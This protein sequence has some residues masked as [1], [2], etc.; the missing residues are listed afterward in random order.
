MSGPGWWH[1]I[2]EI[3]EVKKKEEEALMLLN[4]ACQLSKQ[5][6]LFLFLGSSRIRENTPARGPEAAP[7]EL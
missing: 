5:L 1:W 6:Y 3:V 4:I 7:T 2:A